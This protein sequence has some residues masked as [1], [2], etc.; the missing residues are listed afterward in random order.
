MTR[1]NLVA[2]AAIAFELSQLCISVPMRAQRTSIDGPMTVTLASLRDRYRP[3]IVFAPS[4]I[5]PFIQQVRILVHG[6]HEAR[7][8][9]IVLVLL[10]LNEWDGSWSQGLDNPGELRVG[11]M[12]A[13]EQAAVRRRFHV[14][15]ND[16]TVI[17]I[18]KDGG[19]KLR[20]HQPLSLDTLRSTIDA[21]PM[22]QD[23]MKSQPKR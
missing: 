20:S 7:E 19:E 14:H 12:S 6:R 3:V 1:R 4:P 18:G 5:E 9:D 11:E 15:P 21:M 16:F 23:E 8:R 2:F 17:L 10:P 13:A 22:R